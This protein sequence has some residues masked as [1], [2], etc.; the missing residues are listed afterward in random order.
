MPGRVAELGGMR[1]EGARLGQGFALQ[2]TNHS[3]LQRRLVQSDIDILS[4]N[5]RLMKALSPWLLRLHAQKA[6]DDVTPCYSITRTVP[7]HQHS[8]SCPLHLTGPSSSPPRENY[9]D[10][11]HRGLCRVPC[12]LHCPYAPGLGWSRAACS[13]PSLMSCSRRSHL[14]HGFVAR[15]VRRSCRLHNCAAIYAPI[16]YCICP[17][18]ALCNEALNFSSF[19]VSCICEASS[20]F[21]NH[22]DV[23]TIAHYETLKP[24]DDD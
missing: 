17:R 5:V 19:H 24:N 13:R 22:G 8:A 11:H 23:R 2:R 12:L 7:Q 21:R 10:T 6:D 14:L 4:I 15:L 3:R 9:R 1:F 18:A 16:M 20:E